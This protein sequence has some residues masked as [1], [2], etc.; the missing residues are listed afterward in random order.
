VLESIDSMGTTRGKAMHLRSPRIRRPLLISLCLIAS[1]CIGGTKGSGTT[2][3]EVREVSSFS[4]IELGGAYR[5]DI[6]VG[7]KQRL[8][9]SA[10]DN[11]LPMI[12]TEVTGS[13]LSIHSQEGI[14]P[15]TTP[16]LKIS[17]P[18]LRALSASGAAKVAVRNIR[19]DRFKLELSGAGAVALQGQTA[20]LD[21]DASG[22]AE[23][24]TKELIARTVKIDASGAVKADVR[25]TEALDVDLS[26]VGVVN[27][28]GDPK[29]V[30]RDITGAGQVVKK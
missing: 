17:V 23:V 16:T 12:K 6:I 24:D 11:L 25:A 30:H 4:E 10:D 3:S 13:R 5:V 9:L 1:S 21:V 8:E 14:R 27:Y 19:G 20:N 26:G 18:D 22:A 29:I 2:K 7:E 28:Y 15:K